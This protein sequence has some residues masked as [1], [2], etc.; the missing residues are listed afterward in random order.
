M[1]GKLAL[2]ALCLAVFP[3]TLLAVEECSGGDC[4]AEVSSVSLL[5][6]EYLVKKEVAVHK[7]KQPSKEEL[8]VEPKELKKFKTLVEADPKLELELKGMCEAVA[9][10]KTGP[11]VLET[12]VQKF[13]KMS[14]MKDQNKKEKEPKESK[15]LQGEM[16]KEDGGKNKKEDGEN[17]KENVPEEE[18]R[19]TE[20]GSNFQ[21]NLPKEEATGNGGEQKELQEKQEAENE[22]IAKNAEKEQ[23]ETNEENK[24]MV[25]T[26]GEQKD[27]EKKG[28]APTD[29]IEIV[30]EICKHLKMTEKED[31]RELQQEKKEDQKAAKKAAVQDKKELQED[32][33]AAKKA[34]KEEH[35]KKLQ[36]KKAAEEAEKEGS[37]SRS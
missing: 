2:I 1:A 35:K 26:M 23:K 24:K 32:N 37:E 29:G 21:E 27:P 8:S 9:N 15:E 16:Q 6:S 17:K 3:P 28:D 36:E 12:I 10:R 25:T 22:E 33:T 4:E 13:K 34:E 31:E 14:G 18:E 20:G 5:Q 11:E 30:T 19:P 7:H